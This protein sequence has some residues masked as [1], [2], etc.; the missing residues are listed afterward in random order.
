MGSRERKKLTFAQKKCLSKAGKLMLDKGMLRPGARIG[1]AVSGGMDSWVLLQ[2]LSL[3]R[4]KLPFDVQFMLLHINPGFEPHNHAP[5]LAWAGQTGP[6]VH[7]EVSDMGPRAHSAENRKNSPC[8]FCSWRRRKHLFDLVEKYNLTHLALGH[9]ADDLVQT[10]FLN[11]FYQG[12]VE[13][14]YAKESFFHGRFELIRPLLHVEKQLVR[15]A[16]RDWA[17]PVWVNPCPSAHASKRSEVDQWLQ[18]VWAGNATMR[19]SVY[20]ALKRWEQSEPV[21]CLSR[22][23]S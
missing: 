9:T 22:P 10:F 3:H 12:R 11:L 19:K 1:V 6:A 8:F 20:S 17:L 4:R 21:P 14:L 18:S 7:I 16:V 23:K 2:V 15:K 5:L 13:G